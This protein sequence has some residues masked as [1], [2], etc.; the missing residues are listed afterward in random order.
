MQTSFSSGMIFP[1]AVDLLNSFLAS[2]ARCFHP[3]RSPEISPEASQETSWET[4]PAELQQSIIDLVTNPTLTARVNRHFQVLSKH[5]YTVLLRH[6]EAIPTLIDFL[7]PVQR[8]QS[9][10]SQV[11]RIYLAVVSKAKGCEKDFHPFKTMEHPLHAWRL[12]QLRIFFEQRLVDKAS[13][14]RTLFDWIS[15]E[16][17]GM[18][19]AATI[20]TVEGFWDLLSEPM[21]SLRTKLSLENCQLSHLPSHIGF[22]TKLASLNLNCNQLTVLPPEMASLT[23]LTTLQMRGNP[24]QAESVRAVCKAL[25]SLRKVVI[26]SEQPNLVEM[27]KRDF[28][29]LCIIVT[30]ILREEEPL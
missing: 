11:Q 24:L 17:D 6:Y 30:Q 14:Y 23:E 26:D 15:N 12:E 3:Q 22:L 16:F 18:T 19:D 2:F 1:M 10:A 8:Q 29:D 4:L 25:P 9:P 21:I 7:T 13:Y 5:V 27:F 20:L 28:P